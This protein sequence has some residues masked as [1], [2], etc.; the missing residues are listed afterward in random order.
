MRIETDIKLDYNDVLLRPNEV[1]WAVE[2]TLTY[3]NIQI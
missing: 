1:Q 2:K 3:S